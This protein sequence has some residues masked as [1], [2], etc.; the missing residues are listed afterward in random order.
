MSE[1]ADIAQSP[2]LPLPP[3]KSGLQ[4]VAGVLFSPG[5]TFSDIARKPDILIPLLLIIVVG[6]VSVILVAPHLDFDAMLSQQRE[7]MKEKNPNM[8]EQ[9]MERV[10]RF[11]KGAMKAGPWF[12]PIIIVV[13]TVITAGVLLLAFRLFGGEGSFMQAWSTVLYA[14]IPRVIQSIIVSI[15][16]LA[17]GKVNPMEMDTV[18]KSNL[19]FLVD[20]KE[21]PGLFS[22]LASIDLFTIW[23]IVLL[24]IGFAIVAKVSR[25]K[26]ATI[27]LSIWLLIILIKSGAAGLMGRMRRS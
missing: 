16:V 9:D 19:G 21:H 24:I 7:M 22:L 23:Y 3:P 6:F 14:W 13:M 26:S 11:Q 27:V 15:I 12:G 18:V 1:S 8:S 17:R 2:T 5:E 4:R 10:E 20:I 25:A